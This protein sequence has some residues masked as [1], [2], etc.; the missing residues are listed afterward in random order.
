MRVR[1]RIVNV[2]NSCIVQM[3]FV[4]LYNK[5]RRKHGKKSELKRKEIREDCNFDELVHE[6]VAVDFVL[7]SKVDSYL[8]MLI[9]YINGVIQPTIPRNQRVGGNGNVV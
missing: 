4:K 9:Q 6:K 2:V 8:I 1:M 3:K 7:S 5:W